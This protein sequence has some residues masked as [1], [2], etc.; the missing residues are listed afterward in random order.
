[1]LS[2]STDLSEASLHASYNV[3]GWWNFKQV[4]IQ[5]NRLYKGS[6][7]AAAEM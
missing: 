5:L 3:Q 6:I 4:L 7:G 1:M 2:N